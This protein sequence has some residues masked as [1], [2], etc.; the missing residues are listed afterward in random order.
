[1]AF[2]LLEKPTRT[3][4]SLPMELRQFKPAYHCKIEGVWTDIGG[5]RRAL[6]ITEDPVTVKDSCVR[7]MLNQELSA[8]RILRKR[9]M[10]DIKRTR[11][12]NGTALR[13]LQH[14]Q[15]FLAHETKISW[16]FSH[17]LLLRLRA[18][19]SFPDSSTYFPASNQTI[20]HIFFFTSPQIYK[21]VC[22]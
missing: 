10:T 3:T 6:S 2:R 18:F 22:P 9:V 4:V 15:R 5:A 8:Y 20:S 19:H 11:R 16:N 13:T 1:M 21:G 14:H 12:R 17:R 7:M